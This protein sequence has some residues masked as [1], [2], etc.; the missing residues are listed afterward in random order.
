MLLTGERYLVGVNK[1]QTQDEYDLTVARNSEH[2][3]AIVTV[4]RMNELAYEDIIL[5]IDHETKEDNV[6]LSL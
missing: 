6:A 3:K 5:S 1:I 4:G 2:D